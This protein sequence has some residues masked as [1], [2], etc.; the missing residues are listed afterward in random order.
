MSQIAAKLGV[1]PNTVR[2]M[3]RQGRLPVPD[4]VTGDPDSYHCVPGWLPETIEAWIPT[5]PGRGNYLPKGALK[6]PRK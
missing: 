1:T 2:S 5:R 4:W 3:Y 6:P